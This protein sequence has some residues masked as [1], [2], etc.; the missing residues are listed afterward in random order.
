MYQFAYLVELFF[1]VERYN[2]DG[3]D[4]EN[5]SNNNCD[6]CDDSTI[7]TGPTICQTP[8]SSPQKAKKDSAW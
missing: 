1:G 4:T 3:K 7:T 2:N 6:N 8:C 5:N